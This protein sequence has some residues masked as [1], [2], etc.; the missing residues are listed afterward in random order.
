MTA[1]LTLIT[2]ATDGIGK[3]TALDLA[4][5]GH[6]VILHGRAPARIEAAK[7]WLLG[8]APGAVVHTVCA[9]LS[10]LAE[11][12]RAAGEVLGRFERLDVLIH[13]AGVFAQT[14]TLSA[15]GFEL[16]FAVNHLAPFAL[17]QALLPLLKA[18]ATPTRAA[19]VVTV[20]SIAHQR[21]RLRMDDLQLEQGA[22]DGYQAYAA[23]KLANVLFSNALA[24]RVDPAQ[25][26]SNSLHPGVITTKLLKAGFNMTGASLEEGAATS[27]FLAAAQ[28]VSKV[29]GAYF[30]ASRAVEPSRLALEVAAQDQLWDASARLVGGIDG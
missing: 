27:V 20:S 5:R 2:G 6:E 12:R 22:Y 24:R 17:T 14:R 8:E 18:S 26:T 16:T 4:R 11:V 30:V 23:S 28:E 19:R 15:D 29:T 7:A 3:Q 9:D 21:G 10:S 1:P 13:N 25:V